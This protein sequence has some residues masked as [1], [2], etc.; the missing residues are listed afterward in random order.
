M[1]RILAI[2]SQETEYAEELSKS[3]NRKSDGIFHSLVFSDEQAYLDYSKN[4]RIDMLLCDESLMNDGRLPYH[5][6]NICILTELGVAFEHEK[7][8]GIFKYQSA[9]NIMNEILRQYY[10]RQEITRVR[11]EATGCSIFSVVSPSG[12]CHSSSFALAL[13]MYHSLGEK[14]LFVSFDPFFLLPEEEK[15]GNDMNISDVIYYLEQGQINV[16][17][18]VKKLTHKRGNLECISGA[19]CWFDIYEM[20]SAHMDQLLT[21]L[22]KVQC[23]ETVVFDVGIIGAAAMDVFLASDIVYVPKGRDASASGKLDEMKRQISFLGQAQVLDKM[24]EIVIPHDEL[25]ADG[26]SYDTLLKGRVGKFIEEMEGMQYI[27]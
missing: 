2:R 22:M 3:F 14:T 24:K 1:K 20:K 11:P 5:A 12:G 4:N 6:E 19:S 23:Y 26:Y 13:A 21:E 16:M 10:K 9:E 27:R 25:L 15:S 17:S 18:H 7:Y 8:P